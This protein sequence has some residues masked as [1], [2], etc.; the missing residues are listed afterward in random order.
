MRQGEVME[1]SGFY[2]EKFRS[3]ILV[4]VILATSTN[5]MEQ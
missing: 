5:M 1:S 2:I 4:L 3:L